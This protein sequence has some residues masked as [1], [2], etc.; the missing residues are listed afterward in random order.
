MNL[1]YETRITEQELNFC[2]TISFHTTFLE[3]IQRRTFFEGLDHCAQLN[4]QKNIFDSFLF[5]EFG[6]VDNLSR[7]TKDLFLGVGDIQCSGF[8]WVVLKSP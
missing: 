7:L 1:L 6:R 3:K 5:L 2:E 8:C 4:S